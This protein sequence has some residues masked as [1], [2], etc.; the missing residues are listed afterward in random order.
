MGL[1]M[2]TFDL[3]LQGHLVR[4]RPK[5]AENGLVLPIT[6]EGLSLGLPN[7]AVRCILDS[8]HMGLNMVTFD[9]DLQSHLG[10]NV[11]NR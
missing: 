8:S 4:K 5:L 2:V 10:L 3:D 11:P 7:L 9:L 6:F 1:H